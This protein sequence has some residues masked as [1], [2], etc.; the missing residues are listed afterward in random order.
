MRKGL[1]S[2]TT[3]HEIWKW[4]FSFTTNLTVSQYHLLNFYIDNNEKKEANGT[5]QN[6]KQTFHLPF[7]GLWQNLMDMQKFTHCD[8][9]SKNKLSENINQYITSKGCICKVLWYVKL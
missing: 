5:N 4:C 2:A 1:N 3:L 8:H 6:Q 7:H 9:F